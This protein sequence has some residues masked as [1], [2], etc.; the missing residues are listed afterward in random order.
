MHRSSSIV[1]LLLLACIAS[2]SGCATLTLEGDKLR[3]PW[4][5]EK[6]EPYPN[7]VKMAVMW[8]PERMVQPGKR[9]TR[10]FG[11]RIF[12]YNEKSRAVPVDG[13]LHVH[14]FME[15]TP[16][17]SEMA[18]MR[19][20][21]FTAEQ[22]TNHYS[23]NDLGASYSVWIP[24]D[25]DGGAQQRI[26]LATTFR[27]KEGKVVTGEPATVLL[28]GTTTMPREPAGVARSEGDGTAPEWLERARLKLEHDGDGRAGVRTTT[29]PLPNQL[30][31]RLQRLPSQPSRGAAR[32]DM[33][34]LPPT[35]TSATLPPPQA[36][37]AAPTTL[38]APSASSQPATTPTK[39]DASSARS[40]ST[41]SR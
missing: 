12:F 14:G 40:G 17:S 37:S 21:Q 23:P 18:P 33:L 34:R 39:N 24:W 11:G 36:T 5:K 13:E 1:W 28:P 20:F 41:R 29:I 6:D 19:R 4:Q 8:T 27:T 9:P 2:G 35:S 38:P 16:G 30:G 26:T 3:W 25:A 32:S 15:S 22:F 7:P 10:G 31:N